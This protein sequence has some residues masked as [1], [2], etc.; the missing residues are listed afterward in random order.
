MADSL[1][2]SLLPLMLI[3]LL[4]VQ[5]SFAIKVM[6]A[7]ILYFG[8]EREVVFWNDGDSRP[9][10]S[11]VSAVQSRINEALGLWPEHPDYLSMQARLFAWQGLLADNQIAA[12]EQFNLALAA[13]R[14]SLIDRPGNPY[15]WAQ[16]AEYLTTQPQLVDDFA[17]AVEK[18]RELGPG[19]PNLQLRIQ[20]L[21]PR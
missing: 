2:K 7:D 9:A 14:Q 20:A 4:C 6:L 12:N 21:L 8:I 19:D 13:M 3:V 15:S 18:V 17:E 10:V 11:T 5:A 1:R 16:Y